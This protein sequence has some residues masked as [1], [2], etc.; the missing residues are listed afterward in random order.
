[1]AVSSKIVLYFVSLCALVIG[2]HLVILKKK[3]RNFF[4]IFVPVY[5]SS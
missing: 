3:V 1:M 4:E 2:F 5:Q